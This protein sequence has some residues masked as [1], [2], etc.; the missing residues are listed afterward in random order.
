MHL[1]MKEGL[2]MIKEKQTSLEYIVLEAFALMNKFK[3][4]NKND[5]EVFI[6]CYLLEMGID[7]LF[8][9][10]EKRKNDT[11]GCPEETS[12]LND[13]I[14][15]MSSKVKILTENS[16][17]FIM[18]KNKSYTL[19]ENEL[20]V[21]KMETKTSNN[22]KLTQNFFEVVIKDL[23]NLFDAILEGVE[24]NFN[25]GYFRPH[26]IENLPSPFFDFEIPYYLIRLTK[27][28]ISKNVIKDLIIRIDANFKE[29]SFWSKKGDDFENEIELLTKYFKID[30]GK[31]LVINMYNKY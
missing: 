18:S 26:F 21:T 30:V 4:F 23:N 27:E 8:A 7:I 16:H 31:R 12:N 14:D 28:D 5:R 20:N 13:Y 17:E 2:V 19:Y 22:R 15:L 24:Y 9:V 11:R 3:G 29:V 6:N 10:G 25:P 1:K